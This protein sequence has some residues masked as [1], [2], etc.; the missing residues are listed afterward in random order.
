MINHEHKYIFIHI[1][2]TGGNSIK[3]SLAGPWPNYES[4]HKT[5]NHYEE[6]LDYF[7]FSFVRNPYDRIYSWVY[8]HIE[9]W[10]A[11]HNRPT[12]KEF[13]N[14]VKDYI[15]KD[16]TFSA[17]QYDRIKDK[18]DFVGKFENLQSDF[19]IVC[20][21][22]GIDKTKLPWEDKGLGL[23]SYFDFYEK[24]TIQLINERHEIDFEEFGYGERNDER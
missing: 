14:Y 12:K 5:I 18:M 17:P 9:P 2:K 4:R 22:I 3:R 8:S 24:E 10:Q 13:N 21:K 6:Y 20:D 1:P 7:K 23:K 19:N 11:F 15:D 16:W